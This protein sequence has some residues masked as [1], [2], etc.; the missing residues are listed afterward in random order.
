MKILEVTWD[1]YSQTHGETVGKK[2]F[3]RYIWKVRIDYCSDKNTFQNRAH[4]FYPFLLPRET[5]GTAPEATGTGVFSKSRIQSFGHLYNTVG[6]RVQIQVWDPS[7]SNIQSLAGFA[8]SSAVAFH[9][10]R[11]KAAF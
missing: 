1:L 5:R 10:I 8:G 2:Y 9:V 6:Q 3:K 7:N 4:L 11:R